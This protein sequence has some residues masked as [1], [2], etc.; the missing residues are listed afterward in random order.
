M[1]EL[2][3]EQQQMLSLLKRIWEADPTLRFCQLIGN[4]FGQ[5]SGRDI[6][7]I[8]D[9]KFMSALNDTYITGAAWTFG[10]REGE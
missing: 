5:V 7:Y 2:A 8:D 1:M 6:Y 4:C 3:I 9:A 10:G